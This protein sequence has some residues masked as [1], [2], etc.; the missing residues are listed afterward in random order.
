MKIHVV[1][2]LFKKQGMLNMYMAIV[3]QTD[4]LLI[5]YTMIISLCRL[6]SVIL[7]I[8]EYQKV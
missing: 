2:F 1:R 7:G 4:V 5:R 6:I 8:E 3:L